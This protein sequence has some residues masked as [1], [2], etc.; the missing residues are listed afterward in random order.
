MTKPSAS[1]GMP[2][3][4]HIDELLQRLRQLGLQVRHAHLL[5]QLQGRKERARQ[6]TNN[7]FGIDTWFKRRTRVATNKDGKQKHHF[8]GFHI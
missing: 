3:N 2:Y 6:I 5:E 4:T 7:G 1:A 8:A